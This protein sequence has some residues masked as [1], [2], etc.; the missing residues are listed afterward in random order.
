MAA[1]GPLSSLCGAPCRLLLSLLVSGSYRE[2]EWGRGWVPAGA[3]V[4]GKADWKVMSAAQLNL[5]GRNKPNFR[6]G[7]VRIVRK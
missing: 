1:A 3:A 4:R 6:L 5:G 7:A 2:P